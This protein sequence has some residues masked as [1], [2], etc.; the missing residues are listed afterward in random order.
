MKNP[1]VVETIQIRY[2]DLDPYGHVNNA[3]HMSF[4]ETV[5]M[6]Y[7]AALAEKL[8]V[9]PLEAGDL[10]GVRYVIA[11]A[12]VRYRAPIFIGEGLSGAASVRTVGNRSFVMDYELRGGESFEEGRV[13]AEGTSAQV[14]Y[15]ID[16]GEVRPR[17]DW[18]LPT[19]AALENRPEESFAPEGR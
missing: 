12:T 8:G 6:A 3:V 7:L 4:F 9:G 16:S 5:R 18:F 1:P 13:V 2:Q 11:E 10:P 17:P 19:V 15:D 14:F